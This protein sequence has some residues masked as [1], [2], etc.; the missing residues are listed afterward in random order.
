MIRWVA[1]AVLLSGCGEYHTDQ[2]CLHEVVTYPYLAFMNTNLAMMVAMAE[3]F[4][5]LADDEEQKGR[6]I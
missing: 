5:A 3:Y 1:L 4:R 6:L 2:R